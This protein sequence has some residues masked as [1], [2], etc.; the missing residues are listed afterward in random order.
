MSCQCVRQRI[1]I[2]PGSFVQ[3]GEQFV[4]VLRNRKRLAPSGVVITRS[5]SARSLIVG[6]YCSEPHPKKEKDLQN[7]SCVARGVL[8]LP[9]RYW[10][11]KNQLR[12]KRLMRFLRILDQDRQGRTPVLGE[13]VKSQ[14]RSIGE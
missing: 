8:C 6:V 4:N 13:M 3:F 10:G 12:G 5:L 14:L 11:Q 1:L 7:E 9:L 2:P